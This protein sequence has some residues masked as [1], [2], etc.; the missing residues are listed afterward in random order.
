MKVR[1][2]KV[3]STIVAVSGMSSP[4]A[5]VAPHTL[6]FDILYL[7]LLLLSQAELRNAAGASRAFRAAAKQAGLYIHRSVCWSPDADNLLSQ[8]TTFLQVVEHTEATNGRLSFALTFD[9]TIANTFEHKTELYDSRRVLFDKLAA[10]ISQA[11]SYLVFLRL[12]VPDYLRKD[13]LLCRPAPYLRAFEIQDFDKHG[14]RR[15]GPLVSLPHE[16]FA[17]DAPRLLSVTLLCVSLPSE[18][19][20]A[21]RHATHVHLGFEDMFPDTDG[22][23]HFPA[24]NSLHIEYLLCPRNV[25][26]P[27]C[28]LRGLTL[29]TLTI[30]TNDLKALMPAISAE[31]DV[32]SIPVVTLLQDA[33]D[34]RD[35]DTTL[36]PDDRAG[37][38]VTISGP[39]LAADDSAEDVDVVVKIPRAG[40]R[41]AF[42]VRGWTLEDG[43]ALL[44]SGTGVVSIHIQNKFISG[45]LASGIEFPVLRE[46]RNEMRAHGRCAAMIWPPEWDPDDCGF[47]GSFRTPYNMPCPRLQTLSITS[48]CAPMTIDGWEV[49][50]LARALGQADQPPCQRARLV[51]SGVALKSTF[52]LA[53]VFSTVVD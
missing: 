40:W 42:H 4:P 7:A 26:A 53:A 21:F 18:P 49:L 37:L 33:D 10:G 6:P 45:L 14:I 25:S 23:L 48:P 8:I 3:R 24:L 38:N 9:G 2:T 5:H 13:S 27:A 29:G 47:L 46:L 22:P 32:T 34:K 44:S 30:E 16:I 51:L 19:L 31:L 28:I 35:W 50:A 15:D 52:S 41:R 43:Y 20:A 12:E 36:R 17:G 39:G 1:A 11:L